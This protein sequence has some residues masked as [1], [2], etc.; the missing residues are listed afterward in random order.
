MRAS[1]KK[2]CCPLTSTRLEIDR[3]NY[4]NRQ[5]LLEELMQLDEQRAK[6]ANSYSNALITTGASLCGNRGLHFIC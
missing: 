1:I 2:C 6:V 3:L 5:F 4:N